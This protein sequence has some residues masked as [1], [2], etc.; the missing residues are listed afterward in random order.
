MS[1]EKSTEYVEMLE[2]SVL[3]LHQK[4]DYQQKILDNPSHPL[5][6]TIMNRIEELQK[7]VE[8]V[9]AEMD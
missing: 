2:K 3:I 8:Q 7:E 4:Q 6:E 5:K 9:V 1:K